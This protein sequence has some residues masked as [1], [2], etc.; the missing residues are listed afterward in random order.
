VEKGRRRAARLARGGRWEGAR[1]AGEWRGTTHPVGG[2][3]E[4]GAGGA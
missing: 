1:P 2:R 4:E 3:S